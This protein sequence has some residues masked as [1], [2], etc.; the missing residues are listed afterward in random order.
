MDLPNRRSVALGWAKASEAQAAAEE[1]SA[2]AL[3]AT[4]DVRDLEGHGDIA[5]QFR[6]LADHSRLQAGMYREAAADFR[7][8]A[9]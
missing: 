8:A 5:T 3:E 7:K 2:G 1:A 9:G 6:R 4:A